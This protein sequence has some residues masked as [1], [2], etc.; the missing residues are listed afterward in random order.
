MFSASN[1]WLRCPY[2]NSS[3]G[4]TNAQNVNSNGSWNNNNCSNTYGIRPALM[5]REN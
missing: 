3:N 5:D 1:W 2:C 4:A